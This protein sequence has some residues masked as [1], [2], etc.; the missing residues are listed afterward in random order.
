MS[1]NIFVSYFYLNDKGDNGMGSAVFSTDKKV[2]ETTLKEFR[3][4]LEGWNKFDKV[5]I[6]NWKELEE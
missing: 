4:K 3:K 5:V 6:L 2:S 1:R